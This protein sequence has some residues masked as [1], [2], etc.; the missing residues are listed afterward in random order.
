MAAPTHPR[1]ASPTPRATDLWD[2]R[3]FGPP[4][5]GADGSVLL[6]P[7]AMCTAFFYDD[8]VADPRVGSGDTRWIEATP[9]G[10]GGLPVP[11][12]FVPTVEAYAELT[13]DLAAEVGAHTIVAHSYFAN[14]AIEMVV[15]GRFSGQLVL[16]SPCFAASDEESDTRT[17][18]RLGRIPGVGRVVWG[19]LPKLMGVGMKGRFPAAAQDRLVAEMRRFDPRVTRQLTRHYFEHLEAHAGSIATRL[20]GSGV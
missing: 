9:P 19:L 3:R 18:A 10:F 4:Q 15:T 11:D 20:C 17:F 16:L 8:V 13:S 6:L 14:V 1:I 2:L 12:R 5:P 7:G